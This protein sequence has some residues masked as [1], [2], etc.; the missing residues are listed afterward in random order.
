MSVKMVLGAQWG[1][2]GKG[3][4]VDSLAGCSHV[5]VRF[6][7]GPNAG[8]TLVIDGEVI[9]LHLLPS[10][11]CRSGV[12]NYVGPGVMT[13]LDVLHKEL[14]YARRFGADV[15]LDE[16]ACIILPIHRIIDAVREHAAGS[17]AI[18][19]TKRGMGPASSDFW[20]RSEIT[21]GD[22]RSPGKLSSELRQS[23]WNELMSI[24]RSYNLDS[25]VLES[26]IASLKLGCAFPLDRELT[27]AW[28]LTF[29]DEIVPLLGDTRALVHKAIDEG[30]DVL[31]EGAQGIL[32]DPFHGERRNRTTTIC[33]AA[34]VAASFGVYHFDEVI[35]VAK[36]YATRVGSGTFPTEL[37][38]AV[39]DELRRRG[40]EFGTTTGRPRQCG[41]LDLVALDHA[42]LKGGITGVVITK[43]DIL[44]GFPNPRV[45]VGYEGV[46]R[47]TTLTRS[48]LENAKPKLVTVMGW[49]QDLTKI[50]SFDQLSIGPAAFFQH[51]ERAIGKPILGIGV[52][53]GREQMI[54]K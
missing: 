14:A 54:W 32:L 46:D 47:Y 53:P 4:I 12:Q 23:H 33:T 18:G 30:K 37:R 3:K 43:A 50:T 36:A 16:S 19:T 52:G 45:C 34:G 9:A 38:D 1:D 41:Y 28:M 21:L 5:V 13:D 6:M 27:I 44:S 26:L 49:D 42:C 29:S 11:I 39:G 22:L 17:C 7:G 51:I 15:V 48:V 31:F 2:E 20:A 40:H 10:G 24:I 35:G 8:H 25:K